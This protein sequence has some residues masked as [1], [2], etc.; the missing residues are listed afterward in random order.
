MFGRGG[1]KKLWTPP[2]PPP[3]HPPLR[4]DSYKY[5]S[6]ALDTRIPNILNLIDLTRVVQNLCFL[7]P[8]AACVEKFFLFHFL[9][10]VRIILASA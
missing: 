3:T 9:L 5:Q 10:C 6:I 8:P 4:F 1:L 2:D 7:H